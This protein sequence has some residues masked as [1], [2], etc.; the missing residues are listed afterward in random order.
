MARLGLS[1][2]YFHFT[3]RLLAASISKSIYY[4]IVIYLNLIPGLCVIRPIWDLAESR[5]ETAEQ[6]FAAA[7]RN[8]GREWYAATTT[9]RISVDSES[10][11]LVSY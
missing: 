10:R 3:L 11:G 7:Q 9:T 2:Y 1:Y 5:G 4:L 8:V 6:I